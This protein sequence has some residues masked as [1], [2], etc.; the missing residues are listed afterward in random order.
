MVE[1]GHERKKGEY[2]G[3]SRSEKAE[4]KKSKTEIS[5]RT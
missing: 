2:A 1:R 4:M 3:V 5:G